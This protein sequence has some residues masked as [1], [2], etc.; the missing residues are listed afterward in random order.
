MTTL[1]RVPE[2]IRRT[3]LARSTLY[4]DIAT[5]TFPRPVK[6]GVGSVAFEESEVQE[7][8]EARIRAARPKMAGA[9]GA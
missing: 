4:R 9:S 6:I 8:I 1:L 5:G 3:G 7:W 2:V